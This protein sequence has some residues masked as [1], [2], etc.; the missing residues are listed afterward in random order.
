MLILILVFRV[1]LSSDLTVKR[2][3]SASVLL[4]GRFSTLCTLWHCCCFALT[5]AG[6]LEMF[7]PLQCF[8]KWSNFRKFLHSLPRAWQGVVLWGHIPPQLWQM[9]EFEAFVLLLLLRVNWCSLRLVILKLMDSS[10]IC[11]DD[12]ASSSPVACMSLTSTARPL[13]RSLSTVKSVS[14]RAYLRRH[15]DKQFWMIADLSSLSKSSKAHVEPGFHSWVTNWSMV[16][17]ASVS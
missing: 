10:K 12:K 4:D 11:A 14:N 7:V 1:S 3:F 16:S 2:Y 17:F 8:T 5:V 13:A 9:L 15:L 6:S